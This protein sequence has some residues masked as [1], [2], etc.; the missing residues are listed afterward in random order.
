MILC[1][2]L[3]LYLTS[4]QIPLKFSTLTNGTVSKTTG[5][6]TYYFDPQDTEFELDFWRTSVYKYN[7]A[8]YLTMTIKDPLSTEIFFY[9]QEKMTYTYPGNYTVS[10]SSSSNTPL[11]Y[12]I[13]FCYYDCPDSCYVS[14]YSGYCGG[15]G[16]CIDGNCKCDTNSSTTLTSDCLIPF[17]DFVPALARLGSIVITFIVIGILLVCIVP[18]MICACCFGWCGFCAGAAMAPQPV[19]VQYSPTVQPTP[20]GPV[21]VLL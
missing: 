1:L 14:S 7:H 3:F 9:G 4:A 13:R 5:P 15:N 17:P 6:I 19:Q 16:A 10:I 18:I 20:P 12:Q 2:V 21:Y 8:P 11:S